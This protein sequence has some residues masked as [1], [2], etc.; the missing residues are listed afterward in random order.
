MESDN[1]VI[2]AADLICVSNIYTV[3]MYSSL[4]KVLY[5]NESESRKNKQALKTE[6]K[7][8]Q[9]RQQHQFSI[10]MYVFTSFQQ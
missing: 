5:R 7:I 8:K 9:Q 6:K 1:G 4:D 2:V 3:G 10:L